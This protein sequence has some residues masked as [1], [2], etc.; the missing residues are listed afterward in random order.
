MTVA[1]RWLVQSDSSDTIRVRV[2]AQT[3][4]EERTI[5]FVSNDEHYLTAPGQPSVKF[6]RVP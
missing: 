5:R 6:R 3:A 1:G 4:A 2:S